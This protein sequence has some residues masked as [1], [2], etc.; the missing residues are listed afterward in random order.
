[1]NFFLKQYYKR[2]SAVIGYTSPSTNVINI[3]WKFFQNYQPSDVAGNLCHEWIHKI[4]FGHASASEHD[5]V[6]YA[7]GYIV[8]EMSGKV[9]KEMELR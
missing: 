2:W 1:M 3:N 8:K 4:G 9:L 7:I 6:P 5:S